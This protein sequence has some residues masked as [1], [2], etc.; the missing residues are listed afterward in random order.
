MKKAKNI[1][2]IAISLLLVSCSGSDVY[3]GNWK[4]TDE[5]ETKLDIVFGENDFSITENGETKN[6]EYTQNSVSIKNSVETYG[7]KLDDG[8]S[9]QIYFPIADDESKGAILDANGRPLY[10]IG[11]NNYLKY[12]DVFGL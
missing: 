7:I 6:F 12:E 11:R 3:R 1:L 4:A 10:I 2:I 5:S 9:F 8:R